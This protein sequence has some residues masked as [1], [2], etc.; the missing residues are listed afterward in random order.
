MPPRCRSASGFRGV[1]S[2]PNGTFYAELRIGGFRLTL[3][4]YESPE[5]A[6]QEY[7]AAAWRVGHPQREMNF[8]EME[9]LAEAEFLALQPALVTEEDRRRHRAVQ[10]RLAIAE[11]DERS[12]AEWWRLF[13]QDVQAEVEFYAA[14]RAERRAACADHRRRKAF[15]MAQI[16][17][18]QTIPD[19]NPRWDDMWTDSDETTT[20]DEE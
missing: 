12:M 8:P 19:D 14:K 5:E 3:G 17:D 2:R 4:T 16:D 15:I 7:D 11:R 20:D 10:G 9:S 13:P 1:R 6:A 18:P